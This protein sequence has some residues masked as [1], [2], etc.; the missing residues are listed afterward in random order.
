MVVVD[1]LPC[2]SF[3]ERILGELQAKEFTIVFRVGIIPRL[4]NIRIQ[5]PSGLGI[6]G[7]RLTIT[8]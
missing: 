5:P 1:F 6:I 8:V 3:F 4:L 7:P 2:Y